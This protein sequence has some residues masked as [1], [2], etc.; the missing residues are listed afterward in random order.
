[1]KKKMTVLL[2]CM[3]LLSALVLPVSAETG[4]YVTDQAGLLLP[5]EIAS[6]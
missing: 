6:A 1:M 5:E 4:S 2:V 3:L